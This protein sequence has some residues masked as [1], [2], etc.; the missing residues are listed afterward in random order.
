M[1]HNK[2]VGDSKADSVRVRGLLLLQSPIF[3]AT[4]PLLIYFQRDAASGIIR[5]RAKPS[6]VASSTLIPGEDKVRTSG[7][8]PGV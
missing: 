6:P 2:A 4:L 5:I 8:H 1:E 3:Y 7:F